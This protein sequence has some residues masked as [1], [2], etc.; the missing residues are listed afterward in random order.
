MLRALPI[1]LAAV[2]VL[3]ACAGEDDPTYVTQPSR[4][5]RPPGNFPDV[6]SCLAT[7]EPGSL[8][9]CSLTVD[10]CPDG[11]AE[12]VFTDILNTARYGIYGDRVELRLV[13][14][15]DIPDEM[16]FTIQPDGALISMDGDGK[17]FALESPPRYPIYACEP[18]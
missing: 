16:T 6:E 11:R 17:P 4:Y 15:G 13:G 3:P 12:V 18:E 7:R 10:L 5:S 1:A 9:N 14:A 8:F 2:A